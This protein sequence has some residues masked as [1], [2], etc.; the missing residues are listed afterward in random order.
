MK[1][2]H[3]KTLRETSSHRGTVVDLNPPEDPKGVGVVL[4]NTEVTHI[5]SK[6]AIMAI[7]A[8]SLM[9]EIELTVYSAGMT[10]EG[11]C[12]V[13]ILRRLNR[14]AKQALMQELFT[15]ELAKMGEGNE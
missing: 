1:E 7:G 5:V 14:P 11:W 3:L 4:N 9:A 12:S 15:Q 8:Y 6:E 2:L 10:K 13:I